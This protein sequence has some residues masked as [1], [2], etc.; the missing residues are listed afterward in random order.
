MQKSQERNR[1]YKKNKMEIIELK[2]R[3][4]EIKKSLNGLNSRA[5]MIEDRIS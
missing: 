4:T 3:I 1:S 5:E 2:N